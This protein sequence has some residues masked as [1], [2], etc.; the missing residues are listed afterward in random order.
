MDF[1]VSEMSTKVSI[2]IDEK[3]LGAIQS[4]EEDF[5]VING[6]PSVTISIERFIY[7]DFSLLGYMLENPEIKLS[8][9]VG[10]HQANYEGMKLVKGSRTFKAE[11]YLYTETLTLTANPTGKD[12]EMLKDYVKLL[13]ET[14][15]PSSE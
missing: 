9:K 13:R 4:L 14:R 1:E 7:N 3:P 8:V 5:K 15:V 6:V 2:L 11:D 10:N 12:L